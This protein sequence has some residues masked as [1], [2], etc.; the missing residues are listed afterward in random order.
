MDKPGTLPISAYRTPLAVESMEHEEEPPMQAE[1]GA[2]AAEVSCSEAEDEVTENEYDSE[3]EESDSEEEA[4][5]QEAEESEETSFVPIAINQ[6]SRSGR[7][8]GPVCLDLICESVMTLLSMNTQQ[9]TVHNKTVVRLVTPL[10][11]NTQQLYIGLHVDVTCVGYV[12]DKG[13]VRKSGSNV[14]FCF[15][16]FF[17]IRSRPDDTWGGLCF[18][19][20]FFFKKRL[21]SKK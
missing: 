12:N 17:S 13:R 21:L 5:E 3:S 7:V 8:I 2:E 11:M 20:V 9:S 10:T 14:M 15:V 6:H 4:Q 16:L 18:V 19:F 1:V